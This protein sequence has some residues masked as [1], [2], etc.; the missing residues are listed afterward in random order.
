MIIQDTLST[1]AKAVIKTSTPLLREYGESIAKRTYDILFEKYPQVKPLFAKAPSNQPHLL[2]RSIM[3]F[4]EN[5]D[6]LD[7]IMKDLE[8]IS[9]R[10]VAADVHPGHYTMFGQSLL[11]AVQEILGKQASEE[12]IC[13]WKDAYFFFA[14]ILIERERE[15]STN[16][17]AKE[18]TDVA[19]A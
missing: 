19:T 4:C 1:K 13:A 16:C 17:A 6:N 11:Q 9:Q 12:I 5:V 3:A 2:A 14:D 10:H 18:R 7:S 8:I 15:L